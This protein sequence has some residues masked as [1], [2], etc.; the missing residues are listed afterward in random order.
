MMGMSES[1]ALSLGENK[2]NAKPDL[3]ILG[4]VPARFS[5]AACE[6]SVGGQS[7]GV[8]RRMSGDAAT[9]SCISM[10]GI[11]KHPSRSQRW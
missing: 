7:I 8:P 11:A 9:R 10:S 3:V 6:V 2:V 5:E 4:E 1:A